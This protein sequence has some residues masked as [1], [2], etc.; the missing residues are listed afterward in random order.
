M[1]TV[2]R[3]LFFHL[4]G[5]FCRCSNGKHQHAP[6]CGDVGRCQL[7]GV[8]MRGSDRHLLLLLLCQLRFDVKQLSVS[9]QLDRYVLYRIPVLPIYLNDLRYLFAHELMAVMMFFLFQNKKHPILSSNWE[10]S[11]KGRLEM[12]ILLA[13]ITLARE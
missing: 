2:D 5:M 4:C 11:N 7:P 13:N 6:G 3:N 9:G 10:I 8:G 12:I 1:Y